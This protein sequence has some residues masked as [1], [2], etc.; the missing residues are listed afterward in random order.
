MAEENVVKLVDTSGREISGQVEG[1]SDEAVVFR[2]KGRSVATIPLEKLSADSRA[3]LLKLD[4]EGKISAGSWPIRGD[5]SSPYRF[6]T[7][8]REW[9]GQHVRLFLPEEPKNRRSASEVAF[10]QTIDTV[11]A[12]AKAMPLGGLV[13]PSRKFEC[14]IL[15]EAGYQAISDKVENRRRTKLAKALPV[16]RADPFGV[17]P[18]TEAMR[19]QS[20]TIFAR[21]VRWT[22]DE[23]STILYFGPE[24]P[25]NLLEKDSDPEQRFSYQERRRA[26]C[27]AA[28]TLAF[29]EAL[30]EFPQELIPGLFTYFETITL[31]AGE[32]LNYS[33][34]RSGFEKL[35]SEGIPGGGSTRSK[36]GDPSV[37]AIREDGFEVESDMDAALIVYYLLHFEGKGQAQ[38]LAA[39]FRTMKKE[40]PAIQAKID[41]AKEA[42]DR[43]Q[44]QLMAYNREALVF[45]KRL[46]DYKKAAAGG[47]QAQ[48]PGNPPVRPIEP[49]II[50]VFQSPDALKLLASS[51]NTI[52]MTALRNGKSPKEFAADF[53]A[54]MGAFVK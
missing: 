31:A 43:Y 11:I 16:R 36:F 25:G 26:I 23:E 41:T 42:F 29:G 8:P 44:T 21:A 54:T 4:L 18:V 12:A 10:L 24:A 7:A 45:N 2:M 47:Q 14:Q 20:Q 28:A 33:T 30:E 1:L 17:S 19:R 52:G 37:R 49:E 50:K 9:I 35:C 38:G 22:W 6:G 3:L 51:S 34:L 15:N 5:I 53:R 46:A 48:P 13:E 40:R 39:W 32:G 27:C